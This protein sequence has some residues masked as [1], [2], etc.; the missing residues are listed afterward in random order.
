MKTAVLGIDIQ[1]DFTRLNGKLYVNGAENDVLTM[2]SFL[3]DCGKFIDYI[4]L[5]IDS[6]QPIHIANQIY[7]K[8]K[9]GYPPE[10]FTTI[11]ADDVEDEKW[12]PQYNKLSA[13]DYLR[14]LESTGQKCTIWPIHCVEGSWGWAINESIYKALHA[15]AVRYNR[16]YQLF[17]KGQNQATEHYSIF[18]AAVEFPDAPETKLNTHLLDILESYDRILVMGEAADFCVVNSLHDMITVRPEMAER[19]IIVSDCMSWIDSNN[20]RAMA[21]FDEARQNGVRFMTSTELK[22]NE[23]R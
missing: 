10:I 13:L 7:W 18:R 20:H 2:Y 4:A 12:Y 22:E 23:L 1:N 11:T 9:E 17:F 16:Q 6:H 15:W 19:I 5:S 3:V 14:K 21:L 8:D